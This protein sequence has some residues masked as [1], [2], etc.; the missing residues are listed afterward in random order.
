MAKNYFLF[1]LLWSNYTI[2]SS[3]SKTLEELS[4]KNLLDIFVLS[5]KDLLVDNIETLPKDV[6]NK[7]LRETSLL[8]LDNI[9]YSFCSIGKP[10]F[11]KISAL[12]YSQDGRYLNVNYQCKHKNKTGNIIIQRDTSPTS[13]LLQS[14]PFLETYIPFRAKVQCIAYDPV[15]PEIAVC[16]KGINKVSYYRLHQATVDEIILLKIMQTWL[17]LKKHSKEIKNKK[18]L[19]NQITKDLLLNKKTVLT[20]WNSLPAYFTSACLSKIF[21]Q[22][23]NYGK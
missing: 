5:S 21:R 9:W 10:T 13:C 20:I 17:C 8:G 6:K 16:F 11:N 12:S 18:L 2:F 22:I 7:I 19:L 3:E 15:R 14:V 23:Q 1:I 4:K